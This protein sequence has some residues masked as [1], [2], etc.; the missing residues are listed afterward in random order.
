MST[1]CRI[2]QT[3]RP[4]RICPAA[5]GE[6]CAICCG[7]QR[8]VTLECPFDCPYL[9]EAR[10]HDKLPPLDPKQFP[11]AEIRVTDDFLRAQEPL[12]FAASQLLFEAAMAVE[13]ANDHDVR[14]ALAALIQTR[15]TR[16]SSGLI[17][18][19]R[20]ANPLAA[21]VQ[22]GFEDRFAK[23]EQALAERSG[24][25]GAIRDA[26]MLGVLV[27]LQRLE[28]QNNN[29]RRKSRAF[30]DFLRGWFAA[31]ARGAATQ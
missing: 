6:I 3:R 7:E 15:R 5:H 14:E 16:Q 4:R 9:E 28:L 25:L 11:N 8:E 1:V 19:S 20:P 18:D 31:V 21:G 12:V 26:D 22:R 17:Y 10:K 27:F 23:W 30:L 24:N 2:C 13:G 29:G